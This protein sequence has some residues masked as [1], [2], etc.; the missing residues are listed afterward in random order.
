M[1]TLENNLTHSCE[2][3]PFRLAYENE[4]TPQEATA[5]IKESQSNSEAKS[6]FL[7]RMSHELRTPI[8]AV[9]GIS[10][11]QMQNPIATAQVKDAFS[12]IHSSSKM[13]LGLVN[14]ILDITKIEA[15][16]MVLLQEEYE[17]AALISNASLLHLTYLGDK[18]VEFVL[19]IDP[20]I[21]AYMVGDTMR[22]EQIANNVLSNAFKY[23]ESG[24][25]K[26][27]FNCTVWM[28]LELLDED[29][30]NPDVYTY[31]TFTLSVSDTGVGMSKEQLETIF[32]D[33]TR[34]YEDQDP[35]ISGT[36]LG[37]SI[38][39]NLIDMMGAS[40]SMDSEVGKGTTVS[41]DIPQ[42]VIRPSILGEE[43]VAQ[44][45]QFKA[46]L[47]TE[48]N[49]F[50]PESMP[51]GKVLVVDDVDANL[52]VA[53]G[54]LELYDLTVET[55]N[56]GR[57]TLEK[58]AQGNVY[59][60]IFMDHMMPVMN[61]TKTMQALREKGYHHPI[62][63]FTAN[64]MVGRAEGFIK[65]GFDGY[66]SKPIQA[67]HLHETLYEHIRSKQKPETINA[68]AEAALTRPKEEKSRANAI[69]DYQNSSDLLDT[70][71][72]DF[73]MKQK[74]I[75]S[76]IKNALD[77]DDIETA[78]RLAHTLKGLANLIHESE[79]AQAAYY[80]EC[81]LEEEKIPPEDVLLA[82]EVK[83]AQ[84]IEQIQV[85]LPEKPADNVKENAIALLEKLLPMLEL[86]K[87]ECRDL[88]GELRPIPEAAILVKQV[89]RF[90]FKDAIASLIILK[91]I[92]M[93]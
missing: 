44:L 30:V 54:M 59:D 92:L 39:Y 19:D 34:F 52:Y 84:V 78:H 24:T 1:N 35:S 14:D 53:R 57:E 38:V 11:I 74:N 5:L 76:E 22:I 36:G 79:L 72:T 62:V 75:V 60:L 4:M 27:S 21:P 90:K 88:L 89:E 67:K 10:E 15:G 70:L 85:H 55:C 28:P 3:C 25:V 66:I 71:R 83:T 56:S 32:K 91:D 81:L 64:A 37:M 65:K 80:V 47:N 51:Y 42:K 48:S 43:T 2:T 58:I 61:G 23:T 7:A 87:S 18:D 73:A 33:Y 41:I 82:L 49:T 6:R 29:N 13:L 86:R 16:K 45:Q 12:K 46:K 63:V 50:Q 68:A 31:A 26:L 17:V 93:Q 8:T 77:D 69:D 9:L 40:V 20:N